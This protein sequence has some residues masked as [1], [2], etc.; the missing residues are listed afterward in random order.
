MWHV[1]IPTEVNSSASRIALSVYGIN[2]TSRRLKLQGHNVEYSLIVILYPERNHN[3]LYAVEWDQPKCLLSDCPIYCIAM[4]KAANS[5]TR[6]LSKFVRLEPLSR[7]LRRKFRPWR[8]SGWTSV[9]LPDLVGTSNTEC[10]THVKILGTS[11][12]LYNMKT[13]LCKITD[14]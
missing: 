8:I 3:L 4:P 1:E 12:K 7:D 11:R 5:L 14:C 6:R 13:F 10:K 9:H 2:F